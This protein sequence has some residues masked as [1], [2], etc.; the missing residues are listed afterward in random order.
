M[1]TSGWFDFIGPLF[2][3][4]DLPDKSAGNCYRD[5]ICVVGTITEPTLAIEVV[6][7]VL[8]HGLLHSKGTP[9]PLVVW[10]IT[11][12][13]DFRGNHLG[14]QT[15]SRHVR[16]ACR[17]PRSES[18]RYWAKTCQRWHNLQRLNTWSFPLGSKK[19]LD[20]ISI[21]I[22]I[23]VYNVYIYTYLFI[24]SFIH[25][26]IDLSIYVSIHIHPNCT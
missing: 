14:T 23:L 12:L 20:S 11:W 24:Y 18:R 16:N 21:Y 8:T 2:L 22:Y 6:W 7:D 19:Y 25:L 10:L 5:W 3:G 9:K 15:R 17:A 4:G 1:L 26:F 13:T